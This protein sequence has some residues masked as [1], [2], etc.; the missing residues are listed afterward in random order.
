MTHP[1]TL[2][3]EHLARALV[4]N[5]AWADALFI[6]RAAPISDDEHYPNVCIYTQNE[7]TLRMINAHE[8]EK[9]LDLL[10]EVRERRRDMLCPWPAVQGLPSKPATTQ[11]ADRLLDD[12]CEQIEAIVVAL[13]SK[14]RL[15]IDGIEIDFQQLGEI[16][17]DISQS[18]E[19]VV[20][21]TLAQIECKLIYRHCYA[22]PDPDTCPLGHLL[23]EIRHTGCTGTPGE[24][25]YISA[26]PSQ[27]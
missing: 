3:R 2:V 9:E 16:N 12:C 19:G 24:P 11:H 14:S 1:R 5:G 22:P 18:G 27:T 13:F 21:Y 17:T 4:R 23:G 15:V 26:L 20:P 6:N 7:R 8:A 10:I 25:A